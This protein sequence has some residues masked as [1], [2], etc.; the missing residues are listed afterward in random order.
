MLM[1]SDFCQGY[2]FYPGQNL[3]WGNLG[4][5]HHPFDC[6]GEYHSAGWPHEERIHMG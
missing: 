3:S 1:E 5:F 4:C 2:G 6:W